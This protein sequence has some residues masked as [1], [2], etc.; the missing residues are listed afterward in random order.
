MKMRK[1]HLAVL[2]ASLACFGGV[3]VAQAEATEYVH[4]VGVESGANY[5]GP[6]VALFASEVVGFGSGIGCAGIRG[7]SG[8]VCEPEPGASAAV[9]L[10]NDIASEPYI[11]NHATFKSFFSGWYYT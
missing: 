2:L 5:F 10:T 9:I 3:G 4:H 1:S 11:H 7:V 8:V 6:F